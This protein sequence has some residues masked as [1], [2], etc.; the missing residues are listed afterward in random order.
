ME[1]MTLATVPEKP[2]NSHR[3][4]SIRHPNV[5]VVLKRPRHR[6]SERGC[7]KGE[8]EAGKH[9]VRWFQRSRFRVMCTQVKKSVE[10]TREVGGRDFVNSYSVRDSLTQGPLPVG[11]PNV[12]LEALDT[13]LIAQYK[14]NQLKISAI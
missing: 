13:L 1:P 6:R 14:S 9:P 3:G 5:W 8:G 12:S 11:N 7:S 2:E 10:H 4:R